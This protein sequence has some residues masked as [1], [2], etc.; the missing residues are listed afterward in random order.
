M[1]TELGMED[2]FF[3][4][5]HSLPSASIFLYIL[6]RPTLIFSQTFHSVINTSCKAIFSCK[7]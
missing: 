7:F 2:A 4:K 1:P 6:T 5:K 3:C